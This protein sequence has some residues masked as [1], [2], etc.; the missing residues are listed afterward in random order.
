MEEAKEICQIQGRRVRNYLYGGVSEWTAHSV[1]D[2]LRRRL[3]ARVKSPLKK[4]L[5]LPLTRLHP[6]WQILAPIGP[7]YLP[8]CV[9]DVGAHTGWF[10][11][12]WL[13]W[14]PQARVYAFEPYPASF[15]AAVQ[16]YGSDP[17]VRLVQMAVGEVV[18]E[19]VLNV[20]NKSIVSNSLLRPR[21][22]V[23]D[24]L[25]YFTGSVTQTPVA[26]TTLDAYAA[27]N[28][29]ESIYLLKIDVQGYEM[30]VLRGAANM[31]SRVD[32][33]FIESGIRPLY[34]DAPRFSEVFEHLIAR[35]FHL[36]AMQAWHR[37]NHTLIESDMLFRR[38]ELMPPVDETV[39]RVTTRIG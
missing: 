8:H 24:E 3:P 9:I 20:L 19:Q 12:C 2:A 38:N 7:N 11:H 5:G 36:M 25:R 21:E 29:L 26:V 28:G 14:C 39:V 17:R 23:W 37:G 4:M 33:V 18:G 34:E 32:Y 22:S 13:D 16:N 6:A 27:S 1:W 15:R 35:G 10:F 31:L 30:H